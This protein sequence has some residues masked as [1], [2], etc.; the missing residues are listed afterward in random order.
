M[1]DDLNVLFYTQPLIRGDQHVAALLQLVETSVPPNRLFATLDQNAHPEPIDNPA[2]WILSQY[3]SGKRTLL[4][5]ANEDSYVGLS[6]DRMEGPLGVGGRSIAQ[7]RMKFPGTNPFLERIYDFLGRGGEALGANWGWGAPSKASGEIFEQVNPIVRPGRPPGPPRGLPALKMPSS[8]L[9]PYVLCWI[10]Y[11]S[12]ETVRLLG[13]TQLTDLQTLFHRIEMC[14]SGAW[15]AQLT[16][17][18][19]DLDRPEHLASLKA[20]YERLPVVG[21]RVEVAP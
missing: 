13:L 17:A 4:C 14:Q 16:E 11:W 6:I 21:G 18:P 20:A 19:L 10:N 2:E 12:A 9:M 15:V 5:N 1:T 3:F 7:F 8:P